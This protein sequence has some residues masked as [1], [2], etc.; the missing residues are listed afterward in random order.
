MTV[1]T[2]VQLAA[3]N[4]ASEIAVQIGCDPAAVRYRL[5]K[6]GIEARKRSRIRSGRPSGASDEDAT[7][8]FEPEIELGSDW[9]GEFRDLLTP[10]TLAR[11]EYWEAL[12]RARLGRGEI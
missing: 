3:E 5:K 11:L 6:L 4:S 2:W 9:S 8:A 7:G 10:E 12:T 1:E